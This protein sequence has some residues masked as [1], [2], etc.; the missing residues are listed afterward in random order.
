MLRSPND[1]SPDALANLECSLEIHRSSSLEDACGVLSRFLLEHGYALG[2]RASTGFSDDQGR[3][4]LLI[5][6]REPLPVDASESHIA[7]YEID[8]PHGD[9][10]RLELSL[11]TSSGV[12]AQT[13]IEGMLAHLETFCWIQSGAAFASERESNP[14]IIGRFATG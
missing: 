9:R 3:R 14:R 7:V 1:P 2:F 12:G 11:P 4:D 10:L 5:E 6:H 13:T 8:L